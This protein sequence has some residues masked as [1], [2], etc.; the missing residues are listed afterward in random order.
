MDGIVYVSK[1]RRRATE[2]LAFKGDVVVGQKDV[3]VSVSLLYFQNAACES[4]RT[5]EILIRDQGAIR[6]IFRREGIAVIRYEN[7]EDIIREFLREDIDVSFYETFTFIR[8]DGDAYLH[9]A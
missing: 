3:G 5:T 6:H 1:D 8:R 9:G 4:S 7:R 2:Y